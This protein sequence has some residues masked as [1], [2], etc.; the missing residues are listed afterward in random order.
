M[1]ETLTQLSLKLHA[2]GLARLTDPNWTGLDLFYLLKQP[3]RFEQLL[4]ETK[5]GGLLYHLGLWLFDEYFLGKYEGA[6]GP[7]PQFKG[8]YL[9]WYLEDLLNFLEFHGADKDLPV[10]QKVRDLVEHIDQ[11]YDS[12]EVKYFEFLE[13]K[14][15]RRQICNL[16]KH[17]R[18]E[19][20]ELFD[21]LRVRYTEDFAQRLFHDREM[22]GHIS[23]LLIMI[24]YPG[25]DEDTGEPEDIIE[26]RSFPEWAKRAV[27]ARERGCCAHCGVRITM[28]LE[29]SGH[30]DH[31]V[32]L[33][34]GGSNDLVNLQ[35]LCQACNLEKS[36]HKWPVRSSIP[37]YLQRT[38]S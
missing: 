31:I 1:S 12:D 18:G 20:A 34:A 35:L 19:F 28:E 13:S 4:V 29:A 8:E 32:P 38:T 16:V 23:G 7:C 14:L 22:C 2:H 24:G 26:R 3:V 36:A 6:S 15:G 25:Y 5:K 10:I 37:K 21:D 17:L 33:A 9:G 30:V 11:L 27:H